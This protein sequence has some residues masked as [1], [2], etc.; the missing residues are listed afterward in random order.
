MLSRILL[1]LLRLYK[2]WISPL[3]GPRCRFVPTC[4]DYAVEAIT[5]FGPFKG[6]WLAMRRIARCHPL[7]PGGHDPV[8]PH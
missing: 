7:H 2:R 6:S 8:P 1:F 4:S 5:R 3:L